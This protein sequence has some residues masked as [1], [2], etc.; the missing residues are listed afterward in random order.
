VNILA[1]LCAGPWHFDL[2]NKLVQTFNDKAG[3]FILMPLIMLD[4]IRPDLLNLYNLVDCSAFTQTIF[5]VFSPH[6]PLILTSMLCLLS[7]HTCLYIFLSNWY[8][9]KTRPILTEGSRQVP[10]CYPEEF[11]CDVR[12]LGRLFYQPCPVDNKESKNITPNLWCNSFEVV[13]I[14]LMFFA[15]HKQFP[16]DWKSYKYWKFYG[17]NFWVKSASAVIRERGN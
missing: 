3:W 11:L 5:E 10:W 14:S 2:L 9:Q 16:N 6:F 12:E 15:I 13:K 8:H 4:E 7:L 17:V 1:W